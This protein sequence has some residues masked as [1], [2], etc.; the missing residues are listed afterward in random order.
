MV[1]SAIEKLAC[2]K[3]ELMMRRNVYPRWIE[4]GKITAGKAAHEI[5]CMEAIVEDYQPLA[6]R[7]RLL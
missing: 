5:A 7:E 2:V 3:R 4:H 1:I 6:E